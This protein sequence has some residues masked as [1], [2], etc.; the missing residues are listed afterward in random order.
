MQDRLHRYWQ[1]V[2][3]FQFESQSIRAAKF[4]AVG[5]SRN[6]NMAAY[7]GI[8]WCAPRGCKDYGRN[9]ARID[10]REI[11]RNLSLRR[12]VRL[13]VEHLDLERCAVSSHEKV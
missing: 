1:Q 7:C 12:R 8:S 4:S 2:Q 10:T 5:R 9:V 3:A 11:G 6:H 13:F